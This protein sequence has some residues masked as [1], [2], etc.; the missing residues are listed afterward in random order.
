[1]YNLFSISLEALE[2]A[3]RKQVG[4]ARALVKELLP[5]YKWTSKTKLSRMSKGLIGSY[6]TDLAIQK[7]NMVELDKILN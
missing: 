4:Y 1:M 6:I 5:K 3:S 7:G 2:F